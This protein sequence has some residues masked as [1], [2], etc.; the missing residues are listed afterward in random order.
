MISKA[1]CPQRAATLDYTT[2]TTL[3]FRRI[4]GR[5]RFIKF[6]ST[7]EFKHGFNSHFHSITSLATVGF[8]WVGTAISSNESNRSIRIPLCDLLELLGYRSYLPNLGWVENPSMPRNQS[9]S[10][11][12]IRSKSMYYLTYCLA[13]EQ[14]Y[15]LLTAYTMSN[16]NWKY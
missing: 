4:S 16:Y 11:A 7:I 13:V 10:H 3:I 6:N 12:I 15:V 2:W 1:E 14:Q 9:D 8:D 5:D